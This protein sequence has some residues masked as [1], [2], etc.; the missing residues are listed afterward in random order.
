MPVPVSPRKNDS[1]QGVDAS[2]PEV[3][4]DPV[5]ESAQSPAIPPSLNEEEEIV[6]P[7]V[8]AGY[9]DCLKETLRF[10]LEEEHL[11]EDHPVVTGLAAHLTREHAHVEL[12]KLSHQ[13]SSAIVDAH[14]T[15]SNVLVEEAPSANNATALRVPMTLNAGFEVTLVED[16]S[17]DEEIVVLD[18]NEAMDEDEFEYINIEELSDSEDNSEYEIEG[19]LEEAR[20]TE[21]LITDPELQRQLIRFVYQGCDLFAAP[22]PINPASYQGMV[23]QL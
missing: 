10:L 19:E 18:D 9:Q 11:P 16:N 23:L 12:T 13:L 5:Q 22:Q 15:P 21:A 1:S 7:D 17:E 6:D 8:V 14:N 4:A 2:T 20:V 3:G